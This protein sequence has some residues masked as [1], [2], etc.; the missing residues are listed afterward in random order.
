MGGRE[1]KKKDML[2]I[3]LI[4][5]EARKQPI[6]HLQ[7]L[8]FSSISSF[9]DRKV[10]VIFS[11][12]YIILRIEICPYKVRTQIFRSSYIVYKM[13]IMEEHQNSFFRYVFVYL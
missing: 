7:I 12:F 5:E 13:I 6:I 2:E 8:S 11:A 4:F 9:Y 10:Q 1:A 3:V